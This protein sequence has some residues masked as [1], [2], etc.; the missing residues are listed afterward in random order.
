[1]LRIIVLI[2]YLPR[3]SQNVLGLLTLSEIIEMVAKMIFLNIVYPFIIYKTLS[4]NRFIR[5]KNRQILYWISVR[6][7]PFYR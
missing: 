1:M 6:S 5:N 7:E 2:K 4:R 3:S